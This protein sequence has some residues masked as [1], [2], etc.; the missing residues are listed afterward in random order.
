MRTVNTSIKP[1]KLT[2]LRDLLRKG[3]HPV[4]GECLAIHWDSGVRYYATQRFDLMANYPAWPWTPLEP[5]LILSPSN[6]L[7][8]ILSEPEMLGFSTSYNQEADTINFAL[9]DLRCDAT[10]QAVVD[11][12]NDFVLDI[13]PLMN[14]DKT[15][16]G[17]V[18]VELLGFFPEIAVEVRP[19]WGLLNPAFGP[20]Q[21]ILSL[22]ATF[23][24]TNPNSRMPR[25]LLSATKCDAVT[26]FGGKLKTLAEVQANDCPYS[27][28]LGGIIGLID[29][30]TGL[31]YTS[32]PGDEAAC[33][34]RIGGDPERL[35]IVAFKRVA[36]SESVLN[37]KGNSTQA[38]TRGNDSLHNTPLQNVFGYR[39]LRQ[40]P[41]VYSQ[42][43]LAPSGSNPN[44]GSVSAVFAVADH[45]C[46]GIV[47]NLFTH[48]DAVLPQINGQ[49]V[50]ISPGTNAN[51]YLE[52][53]G[54][55]QQPPLYLTGTMKAPNLS[56]VTHWRGNVKGN[57]AGKTEADI[58]GA[59]SVEGNNEIELLA[60]V[61][62]G[63]TLPGTLGYSVNTAECLY[64][65]LQDQR[66]GA[67]ESA[68]DYV[69]EDWQELADRCADTLTVKDATGAAVTGTRATFNC[70]LDGRE[71]RQ[72]IYDWCVAGGFTI[73]FGFEGKKRV[74]LLAE[75]PLDEGQT[76]FTDE[77][78]EMNCDSIRPIPTA[79]DYDQL[80]VYFEDA[81]NNN[82]RRPLVF[83]NELLRGE[84]SGL[85]PR[86]R[87]MTLLGVTDF[88]QA[89]RRGQM[90]ANLGPLS[91]GGWENPLR[92]ELVTHWERPEVQTL[93][94]YKLIPIRSRWLKL[95]RETT[96]Q[97]QFEWFH[98][99]K[100]E[101]DSRGY[102]TVLAQA[103]P[104]DYVAML[105]DVNTPPPVD[106][107]TV[108]APLAEI[109]Q[110]DETLGLLNGVFARDDA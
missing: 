6:N 96:S 93:F 55:I 24:Y 47:K 99:L 53:L 57:F 19:W 14:E 9:R 63:T 22:S 52:R 73:P 32:C 89:V 46:Q 87:E 110:T 21:G 18:R 76:V 103:W 44:D 49:N 95:Y 82:I 31:P 64:W 20:N 102:V 80:V 56:G 81:A 28:H 58:V 15:K 1:E 12:S 38:V 67:G 92:V 50:T 74:G 101:R 23:G 88:A 34:A 36:G 62:A 29:P 26:R 37:S 106:G 10:E 11:E 33:Q 94:P 43:Q 59:C 2:A 77:G 98:V 100:M 66:T 108:T 107:T 7:Q 79:P 54:D 27:L 42:I 40:L 41:A 51:Q 61:I 16:A 5:R 90:I 4:Y 83:D 3:A 8:A 13:T 25:R 84:R 69:K 65:Q 78:P 35:P 70:Q 30:A 71:L 48:S 39:V 17:A 109:G 45:R 97:R 68:D 91:D 75:E 86:T 85:A 72:Q 105:E 60:G 104:V